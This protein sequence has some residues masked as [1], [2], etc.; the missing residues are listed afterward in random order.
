MNISDIGNLEFVRVAID[1]ALLTATIDRPGA[2][3]ALHPPAHRE[4]ARIFDHYAENPELRCAIITGSGDRAFCAGND[5]KFPAEEG[6][7]AF[8]PSGF[9]G[10]TKRNGLWKPII[11]AVNGFCLGGGLEIVLACDIAIASNTAEFGLPEPLVGYAALGGGGLHRLARQLAMKD[12][13]WL[14]LR[15]RRISA[16]EALRIRLVNDVVERHELLA[17]AHG[18]AR[19]ILAC[20]PLAIAATKQ[21]LLQSLDEPE[22]ANAMAAHYTAVNAMMNSEDAR[23]GAAA[24]AQ[25]RAPHWSGR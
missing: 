13:M 25:K 17:S 7:D 4:L 18:V 20:A 2:L 24:F 6:R 12:A 1:G 10:I 5:L 19:D 16:A 15:A 3:N 23:E 11:A 21:V 22:L 14:A 8:P 9:G